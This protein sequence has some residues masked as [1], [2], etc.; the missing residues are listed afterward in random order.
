M[1]FCKEHSIIDRVIA[2]DCNFLERRDMIYKLDTEKYLFRKEEHSVK[3]SDELYAICYAFTIVRR[4]TQLPIRKVAYLL[5]HASNCTSFDCVDK[6]CSSLR[7]LLKI[8]ASEYFLYIDF[9][10]KNY[11]NDSHY[12]LVISAEQNDFRSIFEQDCRKCC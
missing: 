12:D 4:D 8:S 5:E 3:V 1:F 2:R 6:C 11:L 7:E 10:S 9:I